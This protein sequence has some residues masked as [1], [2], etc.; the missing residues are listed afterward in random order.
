MKKFGAILVS[1]FILS[2][3]VEDEFLP[4]NENLQEIS[5]VVE[6]E[7][8]EIISYPF[9]EAG[10]IEIT[11]DEDFIY[12]SLAA[13]NGYDLTRSRLHLAGELS[14]FPLR[15]KGNLPPG[16]MQ[17]DEKFS[18]AV[19]YYTF[20]FNVSNYSESITIASFSEFEIEGEKIESWAGDQFVNYG[21][22]SYI[23]YEIQQ[24]DDPCK[25][26][27]TGADNSMEISQA[28]LPTL[29]TY[30]ITNLYLGLLEPSVPKNGTFNP[31]IRSL[32]NLYKTREGDE[33]LGD[34]T[35]TYTIP[36][37]ECIDS[38]DLTLTVVPD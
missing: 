7:G 18:P 13:A 22:W 30:Q 5:A 36:N 16:Q 14:E 1:A 10:V 21:N 24:C 20:K 9:E 12:I 32:I 15:G 31:S 34:Y 11:N 17:Y 4:I 19:S 35:T 29:V 38:V 37:G 26:F 8:C 6:V 27:D 3:S 2:C 23:N 33:K 25:G 28:I